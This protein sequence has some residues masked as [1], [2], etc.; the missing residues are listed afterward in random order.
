[1]DQLRPR[2]QLPLSFS[3]SSSSSWIL[4]IIIMDRPYLH[5]R[6]PDQPTP[7]I[8]GHAAKVSLLQTCRSLTSLDQGLL[9]TTCFPAFHL[10]FFFIEL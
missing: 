8:H 3:T 9:M 2:Q 10:Y 7:W 4:F 5:I 6:V 1:M